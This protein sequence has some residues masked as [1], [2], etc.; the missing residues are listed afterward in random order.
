MF[1]SMRKITLFFLS[2]LLVSF[3]FSQVSI[4]IK[5][6]ISVATTRDLITFPKNRL[7]WY[8]GGFSHV[9]LHNKL[10]F[11]PELSFSSKGYR[12]VDLSNNKIAVMRLNYLTLPLLLGYNIDSKTK[13]IAGSEMGY[14]VKAINDFNAGNVDATSSFP[15]KIDVGLAIGLEYNLTTSLGIESRY[16]FGLKTFYQTDVSGLRR[17]DYWAANRAFQLGLYYFLPFK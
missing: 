11:Q 7:G 5:A 16:I 13:V 17:S 14:L 1:V 10:F 8:A 15:K 4:G 6:G 2:F 9:P 3:S 12:Y